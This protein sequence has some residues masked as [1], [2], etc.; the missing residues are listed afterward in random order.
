MTTL[1]FEKINIKS[2][3]FGPEST[4]PSL[5][6]NIRDGYTAPDSFE[7]G[8]DDGLFIWY[9][10]YPGAFPY[11]MQDSYD[12]GEKLTALDSVVLEN[13]YLKAV[14]LPSQGAKLWS[15]Y[16]K[17]EKK[18]LL[19]TNDVLRPCNL[20]IRNAWTSGGI[21]WN[22]GYRG[23][24]PYTCETVHTAVTSLPDGTPVVRFYW[25][26]RARACVVQ[27]DAFLP[28]NSKVLFVRTR[29]TN[30]QKFVVPVYWWTNIAVERKP[31]DRVVV[32]ANGYYTAEG[33]RVIKRKVDFC[34]EKDQTYPGNGIIA[35]DYFWTTKPSEPHYTAQLDSSGYG[36]FEA[37]TS[38]LVGRK[39]FIWGDSEGGRKWQR[40]LTSDGNSG[41][42]DEIQCGLAHTQYECLPMPPHTTWEFLE[43]F[44]AINA[45]KEKIFGNFKD[46][47]DEVFDFIDKNVGFEN[48]EKLLS[49][50]SEAAKTPAA[51][52]LAYGDVFGA[53]ELL[54]R[55]KEGN[56]TR[57]MNNHLDFG[58]V[59]GAEAS[60]WLNLLEN[61]SVG[62]FD[63]NNAP[64]SYMYQKEWTLLLKKAI[65][66]ID[67][68]NWLANYLYGTVLLYD[69]NFDEAEKYFRRSIEVDA[70]AW[71]FYCLAL[72]SEERRSEEDAYKFIESA[73]SLK[74]NDSSLTKEYIRI[75]QASGH[76]ERLI[77][78]YKTLPLTIQQNNRCRLILAIALAKSGHVK[79]AEQI[80]YNEK[81]G[82]LLVPDIREGEESITALWF[83]IQKMKGISKEDAGDPPSEIDFRMQARKNERR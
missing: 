68:E 3:D 39:L 21:E 8:E 35:K 78:V 23:H 54:R 83:E 40:Y 74:Q 67:K 44:G 58:D 30:P 71:S 4:L 42:Y 64:L 1:K 15:L 27:M 20:A 82:Y 29:I 66:G 6:S 24:H 32:P 75:L 25:F 52:T 73:L 70:N 19:F 14:F 43:C 51:K 46:A 53:L 22:F 69:G 76:Y 34:T 10:E 59:K 80:L 45:S 2:A 56:T 50:T 12:R 31:G 36:L 18:D 72:I 61:G 47:Q 77:E 55:D 33:L 48:L 5:R 81:D 16:D 41:A 62:N 9:G 37:S 26:E 79:E 57:L 7:L 11:R 17:V 38:K 60:Y 28:E 65:C 13:N 63:K 49:D